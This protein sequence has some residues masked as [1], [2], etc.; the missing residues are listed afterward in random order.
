MGNLFFGF[1]YGMIGF[2]PTV[3]GIYI[4]YSIFIFAGGNG[5]KVAATGLWRFRPVL[6]V[7]LFIN[8][9]GSVSMIALAFINHDPVFDQLGP[10]P[11]GL[12]LTAGT[13]A[14]YSLVSRAIK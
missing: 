13:L 10:I 7:A 1:I 8:L 5:G 2:W 3:L 14:M 12:G 11:L 4:F 9:F 6:K